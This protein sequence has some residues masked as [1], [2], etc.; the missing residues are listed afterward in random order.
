MLSPFI[1]EVTQ[2]E[3]LPRKKKKA[4]KKQIAIKFVDLLEE[5]VKTGEIKSIEL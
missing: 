2:L 1:P 4:L 3:F 5:F